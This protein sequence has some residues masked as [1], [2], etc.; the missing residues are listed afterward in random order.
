MVIG[1][2][3]C[4]ARYGLLDYSGTQLTT[5]QGGDSLIPP[6][7]TRI[8]ATQDEKRCDHKNNKRFGITPP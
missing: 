2:L 4:Q 5:D 8:L 6:C 7:G 1:Q 3:R